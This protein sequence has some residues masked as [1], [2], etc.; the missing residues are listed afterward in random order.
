MYVGLMQG[1]IPGVGPQPCA[2]HE[3]GGQAKS[4]QEYMSFLSTFW[5]CSA[6]IFCRN[7]RIVRK[8]AAKKGK[9]HAKKKQSDAG[10][11]SW[12]DVP[13]VS[14]GGTEFCSESAQCQ[15]ATQ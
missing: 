7:R 1:I 6:E 3:H 9:L 4:F 12:A 2:Q 14:G 10:D 15:C 11:H 5:D 8:S 13:L